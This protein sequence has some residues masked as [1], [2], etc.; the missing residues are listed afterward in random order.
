MPS[1][2]GFAQGELILSKFIGIDFSGGARPWRQTVSKPTVWLATLRQG[3]GNN[4]LESVIPVQQLSGTGTPFNRLV[5]L[6]AAGE[7]DAATIDAPF[8]LPSRHLPPGKH[9]EL[10]RSIRALPNA[11]DRD[12][13]LGSAIVLLGE[14]VTVKHEPKP[15]RETERYWAERGVN[16]RSTMWSGIRG[17]A[18]FAAACLRLLELVGRPIWPWH[19][20]QPGILGEAFPAAQLY[21]WGLPHRAYSKPSQTENREAIVRG[22][23]ARASIDPVDERKLLDSPDALDAVIAAFAAIAISKGEVANFSKPSEEG[24]IA[25]AS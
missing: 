16:T 13:P 18:P 8:S 14:N 1:G 9:A 5:K 7:F 20:P 25:V 3:G 12:F 6:I 4:R 15:L 11:P 10:L 24:F 21:Q 22:L 2:C 17:G 23:S 19:D